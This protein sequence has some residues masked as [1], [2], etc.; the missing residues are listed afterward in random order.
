MK[1]TTRKPEK[2]NNFGPEGCSLC[3][4]KK[5]AKAQSSFTSNE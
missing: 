5:L 2:Q 1:N 3:G 4:L